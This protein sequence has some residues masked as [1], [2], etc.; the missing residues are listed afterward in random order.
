VYWRDI[1]GYAAVAL[2]TVQL[3]IGFPAPREVAVQQRFAE[4]LD[5]R[6]NR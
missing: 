2:Q 3:Q 4:D 5:C 6:K 1:A